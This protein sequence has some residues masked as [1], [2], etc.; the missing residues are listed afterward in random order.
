LP[1]Q[2]NLVFGRLVCPLRVPL[3][4]TGENGYSHKI[5]KTANIRVRDTE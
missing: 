1:S 2:Q 3:P 4:E 5:A